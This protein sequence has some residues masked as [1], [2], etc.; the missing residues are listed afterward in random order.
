MN[1]DRINNHPELRAQFMLYIIAHYPSGYIFAMQSD[2]HSK[3]KDHFL[4]K[5]I[6]Y[7]EGKVVKRMAPD[8]YALRLHGNPRNGT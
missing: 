5:R 4:P 7:D 8:A 2:D 1:N 3:N 6:L